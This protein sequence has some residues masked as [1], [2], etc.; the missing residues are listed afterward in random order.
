LATAHAADEPPQPTTEGDQRLIDR[1]DKLQE[2]RRKP[3]AD[4]AGEDLGAA[5]PES[6]LASLARLMRGVEQRMR[7]DDTSVA[8]QQLQSDIAAELAK[9]LETAEQQAASRSS[10]APVDKSSDQTSKANPDG[11]EGDPRS[12]NADG[13]NDQSD[14]LDVVWGTLPERLRQQIQSPLQ[15][16]FL[17]RYEQVIK[18]YYKRLAEEQRRLRD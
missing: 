11:T 10:A 1:L 6:T 2:P 16:E 12:R 17:P 4:I 9:M 14:L 15:E 13:A 8:T 18:Q 7:R 5:R 3:S